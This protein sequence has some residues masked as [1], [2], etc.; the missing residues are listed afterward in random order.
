MKKI[1]SF[2][3]P[4]FFIAG[5]TIENSMNEA[6][7]T[8]TIALFG[9]I[10]SPDSTLTRTTLGEN[11]LSTIWNTDDSIGVFSASTS[12]S[13]FTISAGG[14]T[15]A[16]YF[17]GSIEGA[18][19][20]VYYPYRKTA[21]SSASSIAG[22]LSREQV[23]NGTNP[24]IAHMDI[25]VSADIRGNSS[26]GYRIY[27][28]PV[29]SMISMIID[30]TGTQLVGDDLL[31]V[32]FTVKGKKLTGNFT[33]DLTNKTASPVFEDSS[34]SYV[35]ITLS[36]K[37][38]FVS[39][40][41][42]KC[43]MFVNADIKKGDIA[44]VEITTS[45]HIATVSL[46]ST[47]DTVAGYN[48][49][50]PLNLLTLSGN[51]DIKDLPPFYNND[52]FGVYSGQSDTIIAYRQFVD[53][54]AL[55]SFETSYSFRIQNKA[56]RKLLDISSLPLTFNVGESFDISVFSYGIKNFES[57]LIRVK[58]VRTDGNKAWLYD[59]INAKGYVIYH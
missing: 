30:P 36:N 59:K 47:K 2:L 21:G 38:K 43:W 48:Y 34:Y 5:C 55:K 12:N 6:Q 56:E 9:V 18:P 3:F 27:F 57:A 11:G 29:V 42:I 39:G 24:N 22:I 8:N 13:K 54:W 53:Q 58:V 44:E 52:A 7:D 10:V 4:I 1:L 35:N 46:I 16:A 31:N 19:L 15:L 40:S 50:M 20:Y 17:K 51:I 33:I 23:Q 28:R 37:P 14:G 26:E 41:T 32:Y 45:K 25:K 49:S